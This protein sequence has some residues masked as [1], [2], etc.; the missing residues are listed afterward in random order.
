MIPH[1]RSDRIA[2]GCAAMASASR[3]HTAMMQEVRS[4]I[5]IEAP[6]SPVWPFPRAERG[7]ASDA[8]A[9]N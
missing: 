6:A 3:V 4:R 7:W 1:S 9:A 2:Y 8:M 5:D